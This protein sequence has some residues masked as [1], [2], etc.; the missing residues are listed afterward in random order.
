M[1]S[2]EEFDLLVAD[3]IGL[4]IPHEGKARPEAE[5]QIIRK[6]GRFKYRDV[7]IRSESDPAGTFLSLGEY[8]RRYLQGERYETVMSRIARDYEDARQKQQR[9]NRKQKKQEERDSR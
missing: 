4:Y 6:N 1:L 7:V 3:R 2:R 5:P 8:Y 9:S